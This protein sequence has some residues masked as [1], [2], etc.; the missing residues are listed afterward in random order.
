MQALIALAIVLLAGCGPTE[1]T[2]V[3][4]GSVRPEGAVVHPPE[5]SW[6][7]PLL[8]SN[9][10]GTFGK[11]QAA[12]TTVEGHY[13]F[14]VILD[15]LPDQPS[16]YKLAL[17][18]PTKRGIL[19]SRGLTLSKQG[20]VPASAPLS[21]L[22]TLVQM[23]LEYQYQINP[24]SVPPATTAPKAL[25]NTLATATGAALLLAQFEDA[26]R[27]YLSGASGTAP[28]LRTDLAK[29]AAELLFSP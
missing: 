3:L 24:A 7:A 5:A 4:E 1:R 11:P 12:S 26:Y 14:H 19:L 16:W 22:S 25:E 15:N 6:A 27:S 20:P 17:R 18:H 13:A 28:G 2:A 23:A 21:P 10:E 8:L 9:F 29:E